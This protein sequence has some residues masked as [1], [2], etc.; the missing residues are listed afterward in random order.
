MQSLH[1]M[2]LVLEA[3]HCL[4]CVEN[5]LD[6]RCFRDLL[7]IAFLRI[8]FRL[9]EQALVDWAPHFDFLE[10]RKEH[11]VSRELSGILS[12]ECSGC[13]CSVLRHPHA[14]AAVQKKQNHK[15]SFAS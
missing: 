14:S 15:H 11:Q 13:S 9:L 4:L 7:S 1:T 10:G 6:G 3:G 8:L 5:I 2:F 12:D